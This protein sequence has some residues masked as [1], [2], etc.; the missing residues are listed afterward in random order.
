MRFLLDVYGES[1][2][3][4]IECENISELLYYVE[5][6]AAGAKLLNISKIVKM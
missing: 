2:I 6:F 5:M 1:S 3:T 4:P